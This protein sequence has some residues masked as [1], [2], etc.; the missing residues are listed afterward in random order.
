MKS[1]LRQLVIMSVT[2]LLLFGFLNIIPGDTKGKEIKGLK[3]VPN[4]VLVFHA[5]TKK[6]GGKIVTSGG[7]VL[8]VTATS[9]D[10]K[11]AI[12]K[13]YLAVSQ[14]TFDRAFYRGDIAHR[15]IKRL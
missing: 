10:I 4:D 15:V 14:I 9:D 3:G 6:K 5:G 1:K 7:R 12:D 2:I 8:G 11:R 13:V